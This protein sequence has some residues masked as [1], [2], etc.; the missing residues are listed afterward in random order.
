MSRRMLLYSRRDCHLCEELLTELQPHIA[1]KAV[2][3]VVDIDQNA[4]LRQRYGLRIPVLVGEREELSGYP[5]DLA[6]IR[7]FLNS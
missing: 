4:E 5:L 1:G 7:A 3:E 6:R 2:V